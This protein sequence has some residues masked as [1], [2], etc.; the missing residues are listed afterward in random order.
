[1]RDNNQGPKSR[2]AERIEY[3]LSLPGMAARIHAGEPKP[4]FVKR[5][6]KYCVN[7]LRHHCELSSLYKSFACPELKGVLAHFPALLEKPFHPY[8]RS[9]WD[10][11]QR[12]VAIETH[13]SLVKQIFG[14]NADQIYKPG[15]YQLFE[16]VAKTGEVFSIELF[17]GY[18]GEGS[19][20]IRLC[21]DSSEEIYSLSFHLDRE[22]GQTLTIGALQGPNDRVRERKAKISMLTK[23]LF[24][25]RPKSLMIEVL[26]MVAGKLAIGNINGISNQGHIY[27]SNAYS[28]EKRSKL[29]FDLDGFWA[30]YN[31]ERTSKFLFK[32][33]RT[34]QRKE[35]SSLKSSKRSQYKKRYAWLDEAEASVGEALELIV[36]SDAKTPPQKTYP[37][38]A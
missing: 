25:L 28:N 5:S 12:R 17:P 8:L 15:G 27:Q 23:S 36:D 30:E 37:Q 33:P 13:F 11:A 10:F 19:M 31:A 7:G 26:F 35:I 24:G 32:L 29:Y 20:G 21:D 1:M 22:D 38:A 6:L 4:T 2:L 18:L 9:D 34:I 3:I 14:P 16:F